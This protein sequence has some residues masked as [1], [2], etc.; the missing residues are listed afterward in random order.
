MSEW[1]GHISDEKFIKCE[2][3]FQD[4]EDYLEKILSE[5]KRGVDIVEKVGDA[6]MNNIESMTA[7]FNA[8]C[9]RIA[10]AVE[11]YVEK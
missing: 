1:D 4:K 10:T 7:T 11:K 3:E 8:T 6:I 9:N 2:D 5:V